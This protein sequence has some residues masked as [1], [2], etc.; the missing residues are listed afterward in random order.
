MSQVEQSVEDALRQTK[1]S[2]PPDFLFDYRMK[3]FTAKHDDAGELIRKIL[4]RL[5]KGKLSQAWA[6]WLAIVA[7]ARKVARE[8]AEAKAGVHIT[9]VGKG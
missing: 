3:N 6:Q 4:N 1:E 5:T 8:K 2:L 9:R 7:I